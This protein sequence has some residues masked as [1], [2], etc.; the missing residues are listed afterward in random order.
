MLANGGADLSRV[1]MVHLNRTV[2]EFDVLLSI[3]ESGCYL[4]WGGSVCF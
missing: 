2:V 1:I 4:E 3:A